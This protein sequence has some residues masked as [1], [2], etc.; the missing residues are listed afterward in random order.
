[1][2]ESLPELPL[3]H[4]L[5]VLAKAHEALTAYFAHWDTSAVPPHGFADRSGQMSSGTPDD[6]DRRL[7]AF[8]PRVRE[9]PDRRAFALAMLEF[10]GP[11]N[12]G[13]SGYTDTDLLA[14]T[15]GL[16]LDLEWT[17]GS[18]VV[19]ASRTPLV[20]AG[21]VIEIL[22][23]RP[24]GD[25]YEEL[26]GLAGQLNPL[27][28]RQQFAEIVLPLAIRA[29]AVEVAFLGARGRGRGRIVR[30]TPLRTTVETSVE[31]AVL[32]ER[33]GYIRV[34]GFH[35]PH[36]EADA[37]RMVSEYSDLGALI[38]DVRGNRGGSTPLG[39]IGALMDR[40]WR[41]SAWTTPLHL[42]VLEVSVGEDFRRAHLYISPERHEP[43]ADAYRG[44]L[45]LLADRHT[46]SAAE[47]FLIPFRD[48]G[49]ATIVGE[50]TWGSTG[51]PYYADLGYGTS[52]RV[53]AK[54]DF[55]PDM[56][57]VEG[58]GIAPDVEVGRSR[59]DWYEGRDPA[60]ERALVEA[61]G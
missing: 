49:R 31:S 46:V 50:R 4:R 16:E 40:P 10:F 12:N 55:G 38:V 20:R 48:N 57:P 56:T 32:A 14:R 42:P 29:P 15:P 34:P 37:I 9:A 3:D 51:Q 19:A 13:H 54:R 6:L 30:R 43:A 26:S 47:D 52:I 33:V 7:R 36:F 41:S 2:S 35:R 24:L 39:L 5:Y 17:D 60:L 53:S 11:F 18:W 23:G 8:L 21:D 61:A 45:I 28:R 44:R 1:M 27:S 58:A 22:E 25:W 59:D